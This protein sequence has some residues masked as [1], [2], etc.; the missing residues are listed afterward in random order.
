MSIYNCK[1]LFNSKTV[2]SV[3][4]GVDSIDAVITRSD[5]HKPGLNIAGDKSVIYPYRVMLKIADVVSK[6]IVI[7]ER[8]TKIELKNSKGIIITVS[9]NSII[10]KDPEDDGCYV[11]GCS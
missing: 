8:S 2:E 7:E 4:I 6:N 3:V 9:V 1:P 5:P 10:K 11:L